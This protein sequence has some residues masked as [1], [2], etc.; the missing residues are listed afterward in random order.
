MR[1]P[2]RFGIE[3]EAKKFCR[4]SATDLEILESQRRGGGMGGR[5]FSKNY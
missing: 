4:D 3:N 2:Y 5:T 1:D